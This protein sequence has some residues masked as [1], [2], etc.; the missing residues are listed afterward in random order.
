VAGASE[1]CESELYRE[2]VLGRFEALGASE[3]CESEL[4]RELVLG[5]FEA[6]GLF[7]RV[8]LS[9]VDA[10]SSEKSLDSEIS[11]LDPAEAKGGTLFVEFIENIR[12]LLIK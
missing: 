3:F 6:L 11:L 10:T 8:T 7:G 12:Q 5:R 9:D 2:L 1:F 4:Y